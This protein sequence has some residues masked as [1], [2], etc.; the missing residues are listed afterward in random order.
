LCG[1]IPQQVLSFLNWQELE[2]TVCGKPEVDLE[3]LKQNTDYQGLAQ[4]STT[5]QNFWKVLESFTNEG[6]LS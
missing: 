3:L 1:V 2:L 4:D 5:V 6:M